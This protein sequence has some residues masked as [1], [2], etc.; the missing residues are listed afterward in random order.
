MSYY[1]SQ[2]VIKLIVSS[3]IFYILC[4]VVH[5]TTH[6]QQVIYKVIRIKILGSCTTTSRAPS[7]QAPSLEPP[8][9][10]ST[11]GGTQSSLTQSSHS[12]QAFSSGIKGTF[13][14]MFY[15]PFYQLDLLI[16]VG[17]GS[18]ANAI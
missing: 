3:I 8:P 5:L 6:N 4:N 11:T 17:G 10:Q 14:G 9:V 12:S 7:P 16:G 13:I 15:V 18:C 1:C 2:D